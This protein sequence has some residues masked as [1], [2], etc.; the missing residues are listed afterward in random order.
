MNRVAI[1]EETAFK[2]QMQDLDRSFDEL[3]QRSEFTEG[4][5]T[6]QV[7]ISEHNSMRVSIYC[8]RTH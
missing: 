6:P 7:T 3:K 5:P 8:R 4:L 2:K 1:N